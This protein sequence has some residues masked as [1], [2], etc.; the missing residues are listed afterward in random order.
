MLA[1]AD[2]EELITGVMQLS[3][4]DEATAARIVSGVGDTPEIDDQGNVIVEGRAW[5]WPEEAD[6]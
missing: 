3:N 2:F 5:L 1:P 4:V 6:A